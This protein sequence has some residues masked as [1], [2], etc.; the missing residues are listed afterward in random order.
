MDD[1]YKVEAYINGG[2]LSNAAELVGVK[3]TI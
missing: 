2:S 1:M 3:E